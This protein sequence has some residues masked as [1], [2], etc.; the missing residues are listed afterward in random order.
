MRRVM[1]CTFALLLP[2]LLASACTGGST[3][4]VIVPDAVDKA[5]PDP[6]AYDN[7]HAIY[8]YNVGFADFDPMDVG[9]SKY[10]TY[11]FTEYA[12]VKLLTRAAT[13]GRR[14]GN[15]MIRHIGEMKDIE[16][17]VIKADGKRQK[18]GPK[19]FT[20]NILFK[21]IVPGATPPIHLYETTIIFPG[22][23]A[24]DT[25][26]Y[27]FTR[28]GRDTKWTFSKF[29]APVLYSKFMMARPMR[30][31][32]IQPVLYDRHD[33]GIEKSEDS[34]IVAGMT[35]RI[36]S[37]R[38]T[39]DIWEA[40]DVP[41]IEREA[42]MQPL[43]DVASRLRVW[44]GDRRLS[45]ST[46]GETY[47]KWFKHYGRAP[48]AAEAQAKKVLEGVGSAP[49]E[50]AKAIHDWVKRN[51]A[52]KDHDQLSWVPRQ[53]EIATIDIEELLE[54]KT[55]TPEQ[56]ANLMWLM[57]KAA[58]VDAQL[59]LTTSQYDAE[60]EE[61]LPDLYQFT[62]P[63]LA[64]PDGT[65][66]DASDRWVP[67]GMLPFWFEGQKSLHIDEGQISF[68]ELPESAPADNRL[69][70]TIRGKIDTEGVATV[71]MDSEFIGQLALRAR[72]YY[73]GKTA[74]ERE[75]ALQEGIAES[76]PKAELGEWSIEHLEDADQPLALHIE[77]RVPGYADVLRDKM[78]IKLAAFV[79]HTYCPELTTTER[80]NP[81]WFPH[82]LQEDMDIKID[83]PL[84]HHLK[85]LPKGFR[86]RHFDSQTAMGVQNSYG[87]PDGKDLH[88]I[89]K[90]SVNETFVGL[91]GY[92]LLRK[93]A[94]RYLGQKNTLVT[95][96]LPDMD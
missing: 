29:E 69:A 85:D 1:C 48:G 38:T 4:L 30:R 35:G 63:L 47:W 58:G 5:Q 20:S 33:L 49:R 70:R 83:M 46:L 62:Y 34:G 96:E 74:E 53:I 27:R 82:R 41:P 89:R 36:G 55:A 64:L 14:W 12:K 81:V 24:G 95:V 21:D 19:D 39:Y 10:P 45:W 16:A 51:I 54:D 44:Q 40:R 13:E 87:S 88:V 42:Q 75:K 59:V 78:V 80:D 92:P 2:A 76:T 8:L 18:L 93:M 66:I 77:F 31:V 67:F 11:Q 84:G 79:D 25:I 23:E 61:G 91:D 17:W 90:L 7:I 86:T 57:M 37:R 73:A 72:S 94:Q 28:R 43:V 3:G 9:N 56:A 68:E 26:E 32:E 6:D 15:R 65:F 22:L 52:I 50:R 71:V 60:A